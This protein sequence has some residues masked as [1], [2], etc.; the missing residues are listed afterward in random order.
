MKKILNSI[1]E[2]QNKFTNREQ[3]VQVLKWLKTELTYTSNHIE[4]NTL[5]REETA[6]TV[7]E[8]IT[9]GS[10][11]LKDYIEAKNHAEAFE[12]VLSLT[13]QKNIEYENVILKLHSIILKG[14]N[15]EYGGRYR[16][17]RVRIAGSDVIL[18]NPL[19]VP[20]LMKSFATMLDQ[21]PDS[22]LKAIEAHYKLVE[23]HPFIDG[24]GRTARLLMNLILLRSQVFPILISPTE[25]KRYLSHINKRNLTGKFLPYYS[26]MLKLLD[27]SLQKYTA[28]FSDENNSSDQNN[29]LTIKKFARFCKLSVSAVRYSVRTHKIT[30]R[31]YTNAGYMLFS[32]DQAK[33]LQKQKP[34]TSKAMEGSSKEK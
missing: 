20:E 18:P 16:N 19:K 10:K 2:K 3:R 33:T 11:P 13:D 29:L 9:S 24:N 6:L 26:Y 23:I 7:E 4:G 12:Y 22:V 34:S 32:K 14:I 25:R 8:G 30:P 17:V 28:M 5:S 31:S 1:H 21:K 27:R 15:D